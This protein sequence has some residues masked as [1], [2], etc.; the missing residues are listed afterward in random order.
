MLDAGGGEGEGGDLLD[1]VAEDRLR[2]GVGVVGAHPV[3]ELSRD[4]VA[5]AEEVVARGMVSLPGWEN[6]GTG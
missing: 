3:C 5:M 1:G 6:I 4:V 2:G